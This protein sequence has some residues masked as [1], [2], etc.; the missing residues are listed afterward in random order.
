MSKKI[1]ILKHHNGGSYEVQEGRRRHEVML[2]C[3]ED[4]EKVIKIIGKG[5]RIDSVKFVSLRKATKGSLSP[6]FLAKSKKYGF[7]VLEE[8]P[9]NEWNEKEQHTGVE[10]IINDTYNHWFERIT[11][12]RKQAILKIGDVYRFNRIEI[13]VREV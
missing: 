9:F 12:I 7:E 8:N 1:L 2:F 11:G 4:F 6:F 10:N 5:D 13:R 3:Q